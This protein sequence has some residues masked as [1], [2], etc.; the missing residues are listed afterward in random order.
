M[1]PSRS[2]A[3]F[4]LLS[5][6]T[7]ADAD[8]KSPV[9]WGGRFFWE[10]DSFTGGTDR[11]YTQG[12]QVEVWFSEADFRSSGKSRV[13]DAIDT[14]CG[15]RPE[16]ERPDCTADVAFG[17]GQTFYT[18]NRITVATP[19]RNDHPWGGYLFLSSSL[20]VSA[21]TRQHRFE[22][23]AGV[24]GPSAQ[25]QFIQSEWHSIVNADHPNG[26]SNQIRNEAALELLY[27]YR[28]KWGGSKADVIV[29]VSGGVGTVQDY[30]SAG[31]SARAGRGLRGFGK[32]SIRPSAPLTAAAQE[33]SGMRPFTGGQPDSE[34]AGEDM[35]SG[36]HVF[37]SSL[38]R[39]IPFNTFL[40]GGTFH[41]IDTNIEPNNFT[42][43]G[44]VGFMVPLSK[45][46][47]LSLAWEHVWRSPEYS[48]GGWHRFDSVVLNILSREARP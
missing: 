45:S 37:M 21:L 20:V 5:V 11:D 18:P 26:W 8:A 43:D 47:R 9:P 3:A 2:I 28:A 48:G 16:R 46:G 44:S 41:R 17:L 29:E 34:R 12:I 38:G 15:K 40:R 22:V 24:I 30:A 33:A 42:W 14:W 10:N 32:T 19:Q 13:G 25:A 36:A 7:L 27:A 4:L 23:Q 1:H 6:M 35:R 31:V 39:W